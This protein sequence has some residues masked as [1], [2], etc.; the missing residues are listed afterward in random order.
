MKKSMWI[1]LPLIAALLIGTAV[2]AKSAAKNVGAKEQVLNYNLALDPTNL[3]P[4]KSTS[5]EEFR[6]EY[7][8]FEGLATFGEGDVPQ[9]GVAEKWQVSPDGKTYTF[10]LRKNAKWSNGD[11][12]T[13]HDFEYAW[14]RLLNPNTASPNASTLFYLKNAEDYNN[15]KI[16]DADQ[17]GVK[18]KDDYTLIVTLNAPCSY[19]L[20]LTINPALYPVHRKTVEASPEKWTGNP[21]TYIGNG[22][23]KMTN[24][25]HHEKLEFAPN[26]YYWNKNRVKLQKLVFYTIEEQS[27]ALTMFDTG[28][29]DLSDELPRPEI[30][31]L[32]AA[33]MVKYS[34]TIGT[35]YYMLNTKKPPLNDPRVRKALSLAINR[36]QIVKY[37]T[38]AGELPALGFV[39]YG[40]PDANPKAVFRKV[41]GSCFIDNGVNQAKKLLAEAGYSDIKKFPTI[42][43]LYN[44]NETH[45]QIAEVIQQM[46]HDKLGIN[47]TLVNQESK[48]FLQSRSEGNFQIARSSW[49]GDYVDPMTFLDIWAAGNGNNFTNWTNAQYDKL[50]DTAKTT[51]NAKVR[52]QAM[53]DAEKILMDQMPIIPIYFYTRPYIIKPW[54]KGVRYSAVGLVDFSGVT[55][56]TH[57]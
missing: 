25:T 35:Y 26:L 14:K 43:I 51:L 47:A 55:I 33:G 10:F 2:F 52:Y 6:V 3:D 22:P 13:A 5:I 9:P 30:P 15:G 37:I 40:I 32:S 36:G 56:G 48:V 45:K 27:T 41:G 8:C 21:E 34:A 16:K 53:H 54:I 12:V 49:I 18:A 20:G 42:E 46:W 57:K 29:I 4:A 7:A 17:V 23:F 31:R 11:A 1:W 44:T 50:I 28:Q 24:W 39:P 38:K 19:F